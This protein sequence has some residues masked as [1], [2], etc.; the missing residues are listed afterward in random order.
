MKRKEFK[1]TIHA[2]REKVWGVLWNDA[3]YRQWTAPFMEGSRAETDWSEGSKVRFLGPDGNGMVS[4]IKTNDPYEFMS[5]EHL[6]IVKE[7]VEDTTSEEAK[8]WKGAMENYS[9][10]SF[11]GK[12]ELLVETDIAEKHL[13]EF[14]KIWLEAIEKIKELSEIDNQKSI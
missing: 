10:S 9:L 7:G 5:I 11:D 2:P 12:T 1:T 8:K 3:T 14:Q 4:K 6:G 13:A